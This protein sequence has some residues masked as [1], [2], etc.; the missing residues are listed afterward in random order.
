MDPPTHPALR[1]IHYLDV[2]SDSFAHQLNRAL[3]ERTYVQ[4]VP[5]LQGGDCAW[6]VDYLDKV[7]DRVVLPHSPL[8]PTNLGS[9]RS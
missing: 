1:R 9:R 6:L 4:C 3:H 7:R 2:S 8:K 5:G